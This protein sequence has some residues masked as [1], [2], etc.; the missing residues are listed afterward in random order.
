MMRPIFSLSHTLRFFA[1]FIFSGCT[2]THPARRAA[3]K[4]VAQARE[5]VTACVMSDIVYE[6]EENDKQGCNGE[7]GERVANVA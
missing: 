6:M 5:K 1:F 4:A 7:K 3:P 2:D